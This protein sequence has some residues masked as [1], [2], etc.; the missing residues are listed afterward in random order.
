MNKSVIVSGKVEGELEEHFVELPGV[1]KDERLTPKM[2]IMAARMVF[3]Y[4]DGITVTGGDVTYKL[5]AKSH[6]KVE[7]E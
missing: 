3:G 2:A 7:V 6:R 4:R 5:Y 1:W